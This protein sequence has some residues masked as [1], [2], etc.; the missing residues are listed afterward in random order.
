MAGMTLPVPMFAVLSTPQR[1]LLILLILLEDKPPLLPP[2]L[3]RRLPPYG[4][5]GE[6][7]LAQRLGAHLNAVA[8][9]LRGHV[10][11]VADRDRVQ[12]VFV[13]MIDI[14]QHPVLQRAADTDIVHH[15]QVLHVL[16]E[17]HAA[18]MRADRH[19]ELG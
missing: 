19:P 16:A 12:E 15:R 3:A 9:P 14:L 18:G 6:R 17:A 1:T 7:I 2:S 10:V 11:P 13:E 5:V 4:A 8:G